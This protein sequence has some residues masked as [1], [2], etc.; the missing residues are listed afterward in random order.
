MQLVTINVFTVRT[1]ADG[2]K[3][4]NYKDNIPLYSLRVPT[5]K[6]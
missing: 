5:P 4:P 6:L 2:S 3:L 1:T